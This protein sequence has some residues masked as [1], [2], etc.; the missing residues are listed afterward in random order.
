[1]PLVLPQP[2]CV[3][4]KRGA[5]IRAPSRFATIKLRFSFSSLFLFFI[6]SLSYSLTFSPSL[7]PSLTFTPLSL[8]RVFASSLSSPLHL[9]QLITMAGGAA[10]VGA[11]TTTSNLSR[12]QFLF[13]FSLV[14]SLYVI[15]RSSDFRMRNLRKLTSFFSQLLPLGFLVRSRRCPQQEGSNHFPDL[16]SPIYHD[17]STSFSFS[18]A[19]RYF[20]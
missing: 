19:L 20:Y 5:P 14:T 2:I 1:M 13:A 6:S 3:G 4:E 18:C 12:K 11:Y 8:S 7:S 9:F 10:P 17:V 16:A 15:F